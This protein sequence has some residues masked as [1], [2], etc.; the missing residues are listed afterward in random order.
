MIMSLIKSKKGDIPGWS[1][2][3]A[4]IIGLLVIA[5]IVWLA[6]KSGSKQVDLLGQIRP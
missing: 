3:V 5:F 1:Y 2:I 6:V 4:L